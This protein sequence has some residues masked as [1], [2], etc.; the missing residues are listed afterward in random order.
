MPKQ[1]RFEIVEN[2]FAMS[3]GKAWF[4]VE[5]RRT[6]VDDVLQKDAYQRDSVREY[7]MVEKDE[8]AIMRTYGGAVFVV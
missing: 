2:M 6:I 8:H 1:V 5:L 3:T 4:Q 7:R